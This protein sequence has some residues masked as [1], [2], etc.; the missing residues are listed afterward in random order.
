M[1]RIMGI[2]VSKCRI[3]KGEVLEIVFLAWGCS[4]NQFTIPEHLS[5][6]L[7][8]QSDIPDVSID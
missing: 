4:M 8:M 7:Y 3:K 1:F 2:L 5:R 6:V